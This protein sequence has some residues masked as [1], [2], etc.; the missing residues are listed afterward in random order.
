MR[1]FNFDEHKPYTF[2]ERTFIPLGEEKPQEELQGNL[3]FKQKLNYEF[4][5]K[6]EGIWG[7]LGWEDNS[8]FEL[9]GS[10]NLSNDGNL[11]EGGTHELTKSEIEELKSINPLLD[12]KKYVVRERFINFDNVEFD[13]PEQFN[14]LDLPRLRLTLF[15][16]PDEGALVYYQ[17]CRKDD[18]KDEDAL[19]EYI[20][21]EKA[22]DKNRDRLDYFF[23]VQP[24][25]TLVPVDIEK[26]IYKQSEEETGL[27]F[28]VK[29]LTYKQAAKTE[30]ALYQEAVKHINSGKMLFHGVSTA[31]GIPLYEL[32]GKDK[33]NL[34]VF[35]PT[36][37]NGEDTVVAD[38]DGDK[39]YY[40]GHF[41]PV[42]DANQVDVTKRTLFL[43]HGTFVNTM[44]S[45][46]DIILCK[47]TTHNEPSYLQYLLATGKFEQILAFDHPTISHDAKQNTEWLIG[48][49]NMLG[50]SFRDNP[51]QVFTTSRGAL[52]AEYMASDPD[53]ANLL[54]ME[55]VL[56]FSAAN[57]SGYFTTGKMVAK[58]ITLWKKT[59]SGPAAKIVL[60]L[61]QLSVEFFLDQP[62]C[63]LMTINHRLQVLEKIL[64]ARPN[65]PAL[66]Y[67]CV[68]SDWNYCLV[69]NER[70]WTKLWQTPLDTVIKISLGLEHDWV[71]GS[72][73]QEIVP[74]QSA[75]NQAQSEY[76]HSVHGRYLELNYVT[77][78]ACDPI[79]NPHESIEL[80]FKIQ[81]N[82]A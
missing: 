39:T 41:I 17:H 70:F 50:L 80:F 1:T 4:D 64:N 37:A 9:K 8:A 69:K 11:D 54:P 59:A 81:T 76:R 24:K 25:H 28:I 21:Y 75:A 52:V 73:R 40:G 58:G 61:L 23:A 72:K 62:G 35:S 15:L 38:E 77:N 45:F 6:V 27:S 68:V 36:S 55:K 49:L 57:G 32:V 12:G 53:C 60:A 19:F 63:I 29:I 44:K 42:T 82:E 47:G 34:L 33:Y 74:Y 31:A 78:G 67:K 56:M 26:H 71:I 16:R 30:K 43:I 46:R 10:I 14:P 51:L 18:H 65:N 48:K 66:V 2:N 13:L 3:L 5:D 79:P 22:V 7:T 20:M